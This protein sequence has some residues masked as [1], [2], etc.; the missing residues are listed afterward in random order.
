M[1]MKS[2]VG[3]LAVCLVLSSCGAAV[4]TSSNR[5]NIN[6]GMAGVS[7]LSVESTAELQPPDSHPW[8]RP[9]CEWN[10]DANYCECP[11][12]QP[13]PICGGTFA[14]R[15]TVLAYAPAPG[16]TG[17]WWCDMHFGGNLGGKWQCLS[18]SDGDG[19]CERDVPLNAAVECGRLRFSN[20]QTVNA[21]AP[22]PGRTGTWWCDTHF[23]GNLGGRWLCIKVA[24]GACSATAPNNAAVQ[25]GRCNGT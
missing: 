21:Y 18:V 8:C 3:I 9:P 15:Q 2:R 16:R 5:E 12:R 19:D 10:S 1:N 11:K 14:D 4:D 6:H 23:G 20:V 24:S 17:T 13:T 25:C 7:N 22:A